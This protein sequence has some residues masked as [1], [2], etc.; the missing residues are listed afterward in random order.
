MTYSGDVRFLPFSRVTLY[1]QTAPDVVLAKL[2][3]LVTPKW[4]SLKPLPQPFRGSIRGRHFKIVRV[5]RRARNSWLPVIVGD[6][7]P[8][9][10]GTELRVTMR[11]QAFVAAFMVFWFGG[12][13][14]GAAMMLWSGLTEGFGPHVR[15]GRQ[16][17]GG[18][19]GLPIIAA[20]ILAG[21]LMMSFAFW[22]EV[23]KVRLALCEGL[24]CREVEA[25]NR[26]MRE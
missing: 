5:L 12:L 1:T 11:L 20:M 14:F 9:A 22:T 10:D 15:D 2:S 13:F 24:G 25:G 7:V 4:F 18:G 19:A 8:V 26:L 21:Y 23:K 17:G 16:V 6:V 3:N